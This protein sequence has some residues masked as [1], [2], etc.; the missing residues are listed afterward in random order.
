[1]TLIHHDLIFQNK[2][3]QNNESALSFLADQLA[4]HNFVKDS[5]KDAVLAREKIYPTGLP[6]GDIEIAIPH[7]D[8]EHVNTSTLGVMT[9]AS[10]VEFHN[11]GDPTTTLKVSII[12]MLAIAEPHGQVTMLQKLM[13]IVQDQHHLNKM[14]TYTSKADLYAD[15][16]DTFKDV[17]LN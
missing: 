15:L 12:I 9:L 6:T 3:F 4:N 11:M 10:P 2:S 14:L 8:S 13:S 7:A 5:F 16:T 1:M 17:V